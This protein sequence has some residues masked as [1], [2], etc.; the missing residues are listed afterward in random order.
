MKAVIK[1]TLIITLLFL[2]VLIALMILSSRYYPKY[3][4]SVHYNERNL[5]GR[6][7]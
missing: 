4:N 2:T 7:G 1:Y 3:K 5:S 6:D